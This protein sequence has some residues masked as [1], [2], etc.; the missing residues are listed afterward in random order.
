MESNYFDPELEELYLIYNET[1]IQADIEQIHIIEQLLPTSSINEEEKTIIYA[2]MY[3]YTFSEA[4]DLINRL[5]ASQ[6]NR[7]HG[8]LNYNMTYLKNFLKESI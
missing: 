3:N 2:I 6:I 1:P 5:Q 8:G 7:I 4:W